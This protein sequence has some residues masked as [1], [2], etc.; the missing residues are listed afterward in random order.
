[1]SNK[2]L[3]LDQEEKTLLD[4]FEAGEWES[5]DDLPKQ[6]MI[7]IE[8]AQNFFKKDARINIR[9]SSNDLKYLKEK[10]AFEGM[11][12][13]TLVASILHKYACGHL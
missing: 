2:K 13:Q 4:S 11:P 1:M 7:A 10:A 8:A 3:I 5:V 6:K 12:Y 9:I